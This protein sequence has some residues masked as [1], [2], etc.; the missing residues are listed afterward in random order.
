MSGIAATDFTEGAEIFD[1]E[2]YWSQVSISIEPD[3]HF[4]DTEFKRPLSERIA[5]P[6]NVNGIYAEYRVDDVVVRTTSDAFRRH[7]VNQWNQAKK[8]AEDKK[9]AWSATAIGTGLVGAI[10]AIGMAEVLGTGMIAVSPYL[11]GIGLVAAAVAGIF[12][13]STH[14]QIGKATDQINQWSASPVMKI[15][16]ERNY[17]H[18]QGFPYIYSHNLKLGRDPSY[19]GRLHPKQVEHEYKKYFEAFCKKLLGE[20]CNSCKVSWMNSFLNYN[21]LSSSLMLYGLGEIPDRLR[22]VIADYDRLASFVKDIRNSYGDLKTRER[23]LAKER[24]DNFNRERAMKLQP[25]VDERDT[26]L[27]AAKTIR[28]EVFDKHPLPT[29][30]EHRDA[31]RTY[32]LTKK[33]LEENYTLRAAPINKSFDSKIKAA[34]IDRDGRIQ[35]LSDQKDHQITNNYNAARDLLIR[36]EQAWKGQQYQPVNFQQYFPWQ[37]PA[38]Q[39][40]YYAVHQPVAMAYYQAQTPAYPQAAPIYPNMNPG[41]QAQPQPSAPPLYPQANAYGML[42]PGSEPFTP[43]KGG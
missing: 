10:G 34:E 18:E 36:A 25:L 41:Y 19:T 5:G 2:K 42:Q 6:S 11:L 40:V 7:E 33:T 20:S 35:K 4:I 3:A 12:V 21:P 28:D 24:I 38:A 22:N 9:W 13:I 8:E 27:A 29:S 15:A 26:Q 39:P 31:Q 32:E 30:R 17:A 23:E 16:Q 1:Q 37:A 43:F 14:A